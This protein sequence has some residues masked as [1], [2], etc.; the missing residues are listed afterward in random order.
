MQ[1]KGGG[2]H[3]ILPV[4]R[5]RD[6]AVLYVDDAPRSRCGHVPWRPSDAAE[7]GGVHGASELRSTQEKN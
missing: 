2:K 4:A 5:S 3:D 7:H 6:H 1:T